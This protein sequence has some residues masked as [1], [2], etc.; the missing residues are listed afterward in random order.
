MGIVEFLEEFRRSGKGK[1]GE[2]AISSPE[3]DQYKDVLQLTLKE[4]SQC[5]TVLRVRSHLLGEDVYFVSNPD[6]LRLVPDDLVVYLPEE[7]AVLIKLKPSPETISII[8]QAKKTLGAKLV[9]GLQID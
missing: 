6:C 1:P 8:H 5:M 7:L 9:G 3:P 2:V 4:F